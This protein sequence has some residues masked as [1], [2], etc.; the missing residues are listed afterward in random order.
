MI[1]YERRRRSAAVRASVPAQIS[2]SHGLLRSSIRRGLYVH[3]SA[4]VEDTLARSLGTSRN[5]VRR[6]LHMLEEEGLVTRRPRFGTSVAAEIVEVPLGRLART[7][8]TW[9]NYDGRAQVQVVDHSVVPCP[10]VVRARLGLEGEEAA[11]V[12]YLVLVDGEPFC[13]RVAYLDP[14]TPLNLE[15][16]F[17]MCDCVPHLF[18]HFDHVD[19]GESETSLDAVAAEERTARLLGIEVGSPILLREQLVHTADGRPFELSFTSYPGGRAS[20]FVR[21]SLPGVTIPGP[22]SVG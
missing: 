11:V 22:S 12:E 13:L 19:L 20:F 10:P 8:P 2:A 6:A 4:L 17:E 3:G 5:A 1:E 16:N 21:G 14:G 7:E 18:P 9:P 15:P